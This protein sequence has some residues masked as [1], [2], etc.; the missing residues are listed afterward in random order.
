MLIIGDLALKQIKEDHEVKTIEIISNPDQEVFIKNT[1]KTINPCKIVNYYTKTYFTKN[2]KKII[3]YNS[4]GSKFLRDI[5]NNTFSSGI[6]YKFATAKIL[7]IIES[8]KITE[9]FYD[10]N[11]WVASVNNFN[12]LLKNEII[13]IAETEKNIMNDLRKESIDYYDFVVDS[14]LID[15]D[16]YKFKPFKDYKEESLHE[17]FAESKTY[18]YTNACYASNKFRIHETIWMTYTHKQKIGSVL[19]RAYVIAS[20]EFILPFKKEYKSPIIDAHQMFLKALMIIVS[21]SLDT[22]FQLFI[23]CNYDE[24][25]NLY[26]ENFCELLDEAIKY[27]LI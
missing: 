18:G 23:V 17:L 10:V 9:F 7:Y 11:N 21:S 1:L 22:W 20:N 26:D 25:V 5:I 2:Y 6:K 4:M 13:K 15:E 24:L 14:K 12:Y 27:E 8:I 16:P 19:E 3:V